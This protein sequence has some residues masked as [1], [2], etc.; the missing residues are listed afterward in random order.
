MKYVLRQDVKLPLYIFITDYSVYIMAGNRVCQLV[1][2]ISGRK[3]N[4]MDNIESKIEKLNNYFRG[5]YSGNPEDT[6]PEGKDS[7]YYKFGRICA[8]GDAILS[9]G[10]LIALIVLIVR[11]VKRILKK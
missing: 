10:G 6:N 2:R 3:E 8:I 5:Y 9:W 4:L 7:G 11:F 1:P